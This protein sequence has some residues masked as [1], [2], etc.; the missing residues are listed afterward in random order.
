MVVKKQ[1][2]G[3]PY[4]RKL[5]QG[6]CIGDLV[7]YVRLHSPI[8]INA[9][10]LM[11]LR[12]QIANFFILPI[13]TDSLNYLVLA[14]ATCYTVCCKNNTSARLWGTSWHIPI[15]YEDVQSKLCNFVLCF[16]VMGTSVNLKNRYAGRQKRL[17]WIVHV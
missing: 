11:A 16:R 6:F 17:L 13:P 8:Q 15:L 1:G 10:I 5:W 2:A 12:I 7:K 4:S 9:C 14:I 3:L